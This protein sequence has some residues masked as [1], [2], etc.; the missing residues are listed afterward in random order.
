MRKAI[1][2]M[3]IVAA[4][5]GGCTYY[6][7]YPAPQTATVKDHPIRVEVIQPASPTYVPPAPPSP[8]QLL[9]LPMPT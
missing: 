1:I 8:P 6:R 2:V 9:P 5:T 7:Y 4:L 3:V